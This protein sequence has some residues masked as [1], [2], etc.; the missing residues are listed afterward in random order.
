MVVNRDEQNVEIL[1]IKLIL[2]PEAAL[3]WMTNQTMV[4]S[5][6]QATFSE[7]WFFPHS[8][9]FIAFIPVKGNV[10]IETS[11][12]QGAFCWV[13]SS[14]RSWCF[15]CCYCSVAFTYICISADLTG[16]QRKLGSKSPHR[17]GFSS[18]SCTGKR[19]TDMQNLPISSHGANAERLATVREM[20]LCSFSCRAGLG[21][22]L[23]ENLLMMMVAKSSNDDDTESKN[24][25]LQTVIYI[26][27]P[28][29]VWVLGDQI[30]TS[31]WWGSSPP[32][33]TDL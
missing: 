11:H 9:P 6:F 32:F 17:E 10:N 15:C 3:N 22:P 5:L 7:E 24:L 20:W 8:T 18:V 29:P 26:P 21:H 4:V 13:F 16:E 2:L 14:I 31:Q 25:L 33:A 30:W 12:F 23:I 19:P 1:F 27:A 28:F